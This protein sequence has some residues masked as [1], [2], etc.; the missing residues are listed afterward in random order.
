MTSHQTPLKVRKPKA[1]LFDMVGTVIKSNFIDRVL[2]RYIAENLEVYLKNNW[3]KKVLMHDIDMLRSESQRG[4]NPIAAPNNPG[5]Q[6]SVE[7]YV[8][9]CQ[10]QVL[11]HE[12]IRIFR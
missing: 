8:R 9:H 5:V 7:D 11:N 6:K 10:E 12:A 1:I 4:G 3:G 2:F